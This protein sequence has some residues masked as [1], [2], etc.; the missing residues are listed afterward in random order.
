MYHYIS[1]KACIKEWK[2]MRKKQNG[3]DEVE[4]KYFNGGEVESIGDIISVG[5]KICIE[6]IQA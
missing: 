6:Y 5:V 1:V 2:D 3:S 4:G